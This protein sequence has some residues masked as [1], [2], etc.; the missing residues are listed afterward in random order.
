MEKLNNVT[1]LLTV[2]LLISSA[3]HADFNLLE[4]NLWHKSSP[5][6]LLFLSYNLCQFSQSVGGHKRGKSLRYSSGSMVKALKNSSW[7]ME[8]AW[9]CFDDKS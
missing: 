7:S 8:A 9:F 2:K 6:A 3:L 5:P 4:S 1:Y